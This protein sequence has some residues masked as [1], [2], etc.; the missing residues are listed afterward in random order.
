MITLLYFSFPTRKTA[1]FTQ[2]SNIL[3]KLLPT[4]QQSLSN[5]H[6]LCNPELLVNK[7]IHHL[8]E[9][10]QGHQWFRGTALEYL[11]DCQEYRVVY[12]LEDEEYVF[13]LQKI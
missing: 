6:F 2:L 10:D 3:L 9:T 11:K 4:K 12:D 1:S 8:F 7:R 5:H 13:P